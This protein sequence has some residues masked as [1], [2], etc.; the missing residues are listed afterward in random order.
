MIAGGMEELQRQLLDRDK[1]IQ[2]LKEKTKL[3]V[4]KLRSDHAQA[5]ENEQQQTRIAQV[6][7]ISSC[8]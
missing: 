8:V 5:L 3:Y 4:E 2:S 7:N 6:A 1:T